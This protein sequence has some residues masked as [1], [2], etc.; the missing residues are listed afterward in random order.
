M[1]LEFVDGKIITHNYGHGGSGWTLG[2]GS[3]GYV[4]NL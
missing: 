1:T 2:S 3:A 4:S